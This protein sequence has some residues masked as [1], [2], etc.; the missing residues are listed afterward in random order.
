[1]ITLAAEIP[2]ES[3]TRPTQEEAFLYLQKVRK[4]TE[5]SCDRCQI[6]RKLHTSPVS[7]DILAAAWSHYWRQCELF[8][9]VPVVRDALDLLAATLR[10]KRAMTGEEVHALV[11]AEAMKAAL[12]SIE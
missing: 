8:F 1:L 3:K 12:Q 10:T 5:G 2:D 9:A 6:A 4:G 11:D 7:D